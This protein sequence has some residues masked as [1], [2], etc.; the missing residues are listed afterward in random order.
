M[1]RPKKVVR[2]KKNQLPSPLSL[3]YGNMGDIKKKSDSSF[4]GISPY[5][6]G[7]S[8]YSLPNTGANN[9]NSFAPEILNP[10]LNPEMFFLPKYQSLD[11]SPNIELNI[12]FDHYTR[13]HPLVNNL[14]RLHCATKGTP[15]L[16]QDGYKSIENVSVSDR[17]IGS[18]GKFQNIKW[19]EPINYE[20][21][22]V[23]V[24]SIGT[25][26]TQWTSNHPFLIKK[27][28]IEKTKTGI[29]NWER[30][31]PVGEAFWQTAD[32]LEIGDYLLYPKFKD[33]R[34]DN[35][36]KI[37]LTKYVP[38]IRSRKT[39]DLKTYDF[40]DENI[41]ILIG[42]NKRIQHR[43]ITVDE[44]FSELMGWFL[45][46][47]NISNKNVV[48]FSLNINEVEEG[49]RIIY[50]LSK[51]F[52]IKD[53][54]IKIELRVHKNTRIIRI[55]S[56]F[57]GSFFENI[58][59]TGASKKR[60]PDVILYNSVD[61]AR[62]CI[63]SM[64]VGDGCLRKRDMLFV[65]VSKNL[66]YQMQLLGTKIG[67]FF[68]MRITNRDNC[69]VK[70]NYAQ[71]ILTCSLE[72][73]YNIFES[74]I[75]DYKKECEQSKLYREDDN[76]Y[77]LP[78]TKLSYEEK[79]E[80]VYDI[81]TEDSSFLSTV[82][83]HNSTLPLSRFGLVGISDPTI[84]KFYEEMCDDMMLFEKSIEI[85]FQYF[86]RGEVMPY[87]WWDDDKG[88]FS[89]L[90]LIDTNYIWVT[91]HSLIQDEDGGEKEIYEYYPDE[92]LQALLQSENLLERE[93]VEHLDEE[94]V[95]AIENNLSVIIDPFS[96][97][98]IRNKINSWDL[99]GTSVLTAILKTLLLEDKMRQQMMSYLQANIN[100]V[101]LWKVGDA[102]HMADDN[103]LEATR[104][105][106][107]SAQYDPHFNVITHH[108][109]DLEIKGATG[110]YDKMKDDVDYIQTQ[111]L[112]GLW[113][114]KAFIFSEGINYNSSSV[115]M[116]VLMGRYLPI[117]AMLE[118]YYYQKIF[119]PVALAQGFTR[120]SQ[121]E[122]SHKVRTSPIEPLYPLFDWRHKQ[123][124]MDDNSVRSMLQSLQDASKM[125]MKVICDSLDIDYDYAKTWLEKEQN[126]IYDN[127]LINAKKTVVTS[128]IAGGLIDTGTNMV[129][130]AVDA[131][132]AWA[133]E[134]IG[135]SPNLQGS[136]KVEK[137]EDEKEE[138]SVEKPEEKLETEETSE[139]V[140][141]GMY[142][143]EYV[144][145]QLRAIK[146]IN[147]RYASKIGKKLTGK[148][149]SE[150]TQLFKPIE[151][152][153]SIIVKALKKN[154]YC[155]EFISIVKQQV[156]DT[157]ILFG[158]ESTSYITKTASINKHMKN[159]L[160][161]I[162]N[163]YT[164]RLHDVVD[165]TRKNIEALV[166][167]EISPFKM[168]L[169]K[170]AVNVNFED[171]NVSEKDV[172][173]KYWDTKSKDVEMRIVSN[174]I[175]VEKRAEIECY[176]KLGYKNIL[177]NGEKGLKKNYLISDTITPDT[178]YEKKVVI[179][180]KG[181]TASVPI[182]LYKDGMNL[183]EQY[184]VSGR[185]NL[186]TETRDSIKDA[187]QN[188]LIESKLENIEERDMLLDLYSKYYGDEESEEQWFRKVSKQHINGYVYDEKSLYK[189][190]VKWY[191]ERIYV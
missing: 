67:V 78:I 10:T 186:E 149:L 4:F 137:S 171:I 167:T 54:D 176:K 133:K 187:V 114:N 18:N 25:I 127:A 181:Y 92:Y 143:K 65:T 110:T 79:V 26:S 64:I 119:L 52:G 2:K 158:K 20:G 185:M 140:Q 22:F 179:S 112:T 23:T 62:A 5:T 184:G 124:L 80:E 113:A 101:R 51:I 189:D 27:N 59:G 148:K 98:L 72:D 115:G 34:Y 172:L 159:V 85:L 121:A 17:V 90:S 14:L 35:T 13:F 56:S 93:L 129:K 175:N 146:S 106:I 45:A 147:R 86:K 108:L 94:I 125:P 126:T 168:D 178:G 1:A 89:R 63:K 48:C 21:V 77:Y 154:R 29:Y 182:E 141:S 68:K 33:I 83:V 6:M 164:K 166:E 96:T 144:K 60:I 134:V 190:D 136:K 99:R 41:Y 135:Y 157:H 53:D 152:S 177:V 128:A 142:R 180:G 123:S 37:D 120:R 76:Y 73:Y 155:D 130:R 156:Y 36:Y 107:M 161:Y 131:C 139:E 9:M 75:T 173:K 165:I 61:V 132:V 66:A 97:S 150:G 109:L 191:M 163:E 43:Y 8:T 30:R 170:Y 42:G 84:L 153:G 57:I 71:Y 44:D 188:I 162:N 87:G 69:R 50:L 151:S 95:D 183:I 15:V 111:I 55:C 103:V 174:F 160:S 118:N 104:N 122:L 82:L 46:E 49:N 138:E 117:R 74:G 105:L 38:Q 24:R 39:G 32:K 47:G 28:G 11:G 91:G 31:C 116:R 58:S 3:S 16:T 169:T 7:N 19:T 88:R 40:D 12:W 81:C 145:E 100:P 102:E 70:G